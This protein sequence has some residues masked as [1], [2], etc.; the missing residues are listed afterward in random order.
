M[1]ISIMQGGVVCLAEMNNLPPEELAELM[2]G[3]SCCQRIK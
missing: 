3:D 2:R 1:I